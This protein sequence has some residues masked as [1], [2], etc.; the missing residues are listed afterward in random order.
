[1]DEASF[2]QQTV[3]LHEKGYLRYEGTHNL[4][5]IRLKPDYQALIFLRAYYQGIEP[6]ATAAGESVVKDP[7]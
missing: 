4:D 1:M 6:Q 3:K 2:R 5:Q 7:R